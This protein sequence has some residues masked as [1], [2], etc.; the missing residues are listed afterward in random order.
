MS[1]RNI[2]LLILLA[3]QI[4]LISIFYRPGQDAQPAAMQF[5]PD[6]AAEQIVELTILGPDKSGITLNKQ[7]T[8]WIVSSQDNIPVDP[9]KIKTAL[10]K[11]TA[12]SSQRL[13]T[14]T[15]A[16]HNRFKVGKQYSQ[17]VAVKTADGKQES[18]YMGT[19]PAYKSTHVRL[20]KDDRVFLVKDFSSWEVPLEVS[21]WWDARYVQE[22]SDALSTIIIKNSKG[23]LTL[24]KGEE[25]TW[26]VADAGAEQKI[27]S[28]KFDNLIDRATS[29]RL[30]EYLAQEEKPE[31]GLA[32]PLATIT[33][34]GSKGEVVVR[35][36]AKNEE[37]NSY[38]L[39]S[40]ASP[41][42]VRASGF[43]LSD[44]LDAGVGRLLVEEKKTGE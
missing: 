4:G 38:V 43:G 14:K 10:E 24:K 18:L 44:L 3:V 22:N 35:V 21:S 37:D 34:T 42:F 2:A 33:L 16:S 15:K 11:L 9:E 40:S 28:A 39:K 29:M 6:L 30:S 41:F 31:Y 17:V 32:A 1:K 19:S 20:N 23:T 36:G 26:Q 7:E 13:V 5:F 27:D 12:L 25:N 8:G